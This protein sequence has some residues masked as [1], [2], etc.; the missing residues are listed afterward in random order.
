[1]NDSKTETRCAHLHALTQ[2][3]T[4]NLAGNSPRSLH[5]V[6]ARVS[7]LNQSLWR[8]PTTVHHASTRGLKD[9]IPAGTAGLLNPTRQGIAG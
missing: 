6:Y 3:V 8:T 4:P 7:C 2:A 1:M 5:R 9:I